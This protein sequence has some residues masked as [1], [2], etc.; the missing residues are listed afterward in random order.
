MKYRLTISGTVEFHEDGRDQPIMDR[1]LG[2]DGGQRWK[3]A[4]RELEENATE[5][6][7]EMREVE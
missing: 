2:L 7:V 3:I 5:L 1:L 6:V 4:L